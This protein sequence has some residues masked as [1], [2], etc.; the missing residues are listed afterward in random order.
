VKA[1]GVGELRLFN[2][3]AKFEKTPGTV[4]TPPPRLGEHTDEVLEGL[5]YSGDEIAGLRSRGVV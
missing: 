4:K 2:L 5:G 3:T 1:E